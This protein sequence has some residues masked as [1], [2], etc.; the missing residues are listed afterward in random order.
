MTPSEI[1]ASLHNAV[2]LT[3]E[4]L[5]MILEFLPMR[6]L[7]LAQRVTSKWR[8]VINRSTRMQQTLF[9]QPR[10]A[11]TFW[12]CNTRDTTLVRVKADHKLVRYFLS[13][14][15][16]RPTLAGHQRE[17]FPAGGRQSSGVHSRQAIS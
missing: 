3:T 11:E 16:P 12:K 5:E 17:A 9:F 4:L 15:R 7:L 10:D 1:R 6:D 8:D 14:H 13:A 2:F